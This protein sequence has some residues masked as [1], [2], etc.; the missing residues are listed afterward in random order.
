MITYN[1]PVWISVD[2]KMPDNSG[3]ELILCDQNTKDVVVGYRFLDQW[4]FSDY[5][6]ILEKVTH[7]MPLPSAPE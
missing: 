3:R 1:V 5:E 6:E 2:D 7:W 4:H